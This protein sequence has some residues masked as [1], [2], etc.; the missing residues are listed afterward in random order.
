MLTDRLA[1][2]VELTLERC[3]AARVFLEGGA[4]A[5]AVVGQLG[6]QRF[7]AQPSPGPGVGALE[8]VGQ[9]G[10]LFLI[11]PGSYPWPEEVWSRSS[12]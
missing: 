2:A 10:P 8:P 12:S 6:I 1:Q 11:K 5:A 9:E 4:T 3:V 7:R